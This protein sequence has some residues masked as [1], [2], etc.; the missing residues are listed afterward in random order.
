MAMEALLHSTNAGSCTRIY[1]F[2]ETTGLRFTG[3]VA[4]PKVAPTA[5]VS[6]NI[7]RKLQI[8]LSFLWPVKIQIMTFLIMLINPGPDGRRM[9]IMY[10][11]IDMYP[12]GARFGISNIET[13]LS[14]AAQEIATLTDM[15]R[16]L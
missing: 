7:F 15:A 11:N 9:T 12:T 10:I 5:I 13:M 1:A 8:S 3:L 4:H 14:A 6:G 2:P 16:D